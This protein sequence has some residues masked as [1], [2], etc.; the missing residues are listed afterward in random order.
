MSNKTLSLNLN[1]I[2]LSKLKPQYKK[3][4]LVN[5]AGKTPYNVNKVNLKQKTDRGNQLI[6]LSN[7]KNCFL[8]SN[9]E[10]NRLDLILFYLKFTTSLTQS[11]HIIKQR[12]IK[13][14]GKIIENIDFKLNEFSVISCFKKENNSSLKESKNL[15]KNYIS[16]E[17][18]NVID[19]NINLIRL[20]S[21]TAIF[22][23]NPSLILMPKSINLA[24]MRRTRH[25]T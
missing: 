19:N 7:Y 24:L 3:T 4:L 25:E 15:I 17:I 13:V 11:R 5:K 20:D 12:M 8:N 21:N 14:N 2:F 23:N 22:Y 16:H 9:L 6:A 10:N 18:S 1:T